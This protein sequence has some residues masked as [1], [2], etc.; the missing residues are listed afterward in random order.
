MPIKTD[1]QPAIHSI[2]VQGGNRGL[3]F[4]DLLELMQEVRQKDIPDGAPVLN[5]N[6]YL[7]GL[8][9]EWREQ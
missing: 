9:I 6:Y 5:P 7:L 4:V 8:T 1:Y 3:T 2:T